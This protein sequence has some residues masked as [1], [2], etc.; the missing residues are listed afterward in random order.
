MLGIQREMPLLDQPDKKGAP[1][2]GA[3]AENAMNEVAPVVSE[4]DM[5]AGVQPIDELMRARNWSNHDLVMAALGSGLTHKQV[6]KAR[7]GRRLTYHLQ[8]KIIAA[9]NQL[10]GTPGSIRQED[11]FNYR[12]H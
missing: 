2:N 12:G 11:C 5:E 3:N 1:D 10:A 8:G 4:Q 9:M 6:A 7:R